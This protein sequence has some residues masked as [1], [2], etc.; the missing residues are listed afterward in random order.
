M[1]NQLYQL[2]ETDIAFPNPEYA[3][4]SP[5]GLLAIGG[6]LSVKRLSNAYKMGIFPWFSEGEPIMWWS[7]S[8]RGIV[9]LNDF[10]ISKS[11]RKHLKKHPVKVTI[12]N[13]FAEVIEACCEQRIDTEGTWITNDMLSAYIAAHDAKIAHSVEVWQNGELAG[14]LYG[15]M[16]NG[17]FCGESMFHHHT[18]CSKLAMWALVNWLKRH[19]AH[20]ID[21]QLENP[22]LTSLGAKVIPRSEF[23]TR[24]KLAGSYSLNPMMWQPQEL[25]AIYE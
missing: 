15:I 9:E 7:P 4:T 17:I 1:R 18:N 19:N 21:C 25:I 20:F 16:Q 10:R 13:A 2:S 12:N 11:L 23:L 24:L 3:L 22:Y 6:D 5:D 8:E 14:G